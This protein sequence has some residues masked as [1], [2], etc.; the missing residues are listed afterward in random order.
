MYSSIDT[1]FDKFNGDVVDGWVEEYC[2]MPDSI[3]ELVDLDKKF[4]IYM[5]EII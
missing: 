3:T 1:L 5:L 2:D 4:N